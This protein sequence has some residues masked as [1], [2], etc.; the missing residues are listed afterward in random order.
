MLVLLVKEEVKR[1]KILKR[2]SRDKWEMKEVC[3]YNSLL[4]EREG[5]KRN[6]GVSISI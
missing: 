4:R 5:G 6:E 3:D 2:K 1:I